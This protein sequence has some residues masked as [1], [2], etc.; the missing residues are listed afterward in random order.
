MHKGM[1]YVY[2]DNVKGSGAA[3]TISNRSEM[4]AADE[5]NRKINGYSI[6]AGRCTDC[7]IPVSRVWK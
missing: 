6:K 4:Q 7:N 3:G 2:T 5:K 1:N